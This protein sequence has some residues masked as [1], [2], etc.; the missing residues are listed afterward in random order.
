MLE[1]LCNRVKHLEQIVE[2]D[3]TITNDNNFIKVSLPF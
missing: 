2:T 1:F 3:N